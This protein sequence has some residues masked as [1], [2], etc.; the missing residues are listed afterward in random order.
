MLW[1]AFGALTL[2][3]RASEGWVRVYVAEDTV[4]LVASLAVA[5]ASIVMLEVTGRGPVYF[6]EEVVGVDPLMV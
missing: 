4:E 6:S 3:A 1:F 5:I 2:E